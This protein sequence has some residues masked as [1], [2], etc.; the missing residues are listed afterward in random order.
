VKRQHS[1]PIALVESLLVAPSARGVNIQAV[2]DEAGL[3]EWYAMLDQ[4]DA[5][6]RFALE[7]LGAFLITLWRHMEDESGGFL[8]QPLKLGTFSMMCHAIISAGNLRRGLLRSARY[9]SLV[10]D[11][12]KIKLEEVGDEARVHFE[13][14]NALD[15]DDAFFITSLFIIWI[16]LSCWMVD[17]PILLDRV[18]FQF[19]KPSYSDEFDLMFPCRHVFGQ[20][21]NLF[22]FNRRMLALPIK[23]DPY[24]LVDFLNHAPQSLLT[25]FRADDSVTAQV[26]RL[27]T[28]AS[29]ESEPHAWVHASLT[30]D[31][32]AETLGSTT[33][34]LRRRLKEEGHS[35]QEIKDSIRREKALELL[36]Q[37]DQTVQQISDILGFS[38]PA[39]FNRAFKKWTGQ[40]PSAY[41]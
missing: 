5:Q 4:G 21:H 30:F 7:D 32:V 20:K 28:I 34:T 35:F 23:Q 33:H 18:E 26:K 36:E 15:V 12:L 41:R 13:W 9:I 24:A 17:R 27:L 22:A 19:N 29:M 31:D 37:S 2:C 14:S 11:D 16:R 3:P 1:L 25:Q 8:S 40:S 38:E 10:S 39:A 6:T